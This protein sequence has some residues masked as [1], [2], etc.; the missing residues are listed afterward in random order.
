MTRARTHVLSWPTI[1]S[2][3]ASPSDDADPP[4]IPARDRPVTVED[5]IERA[6]VCQPGDR[7]G[8]LQALDLTTG[9]DKLIAQIRRILSLRP[10]RRQRITDDGEHQ[11][12]RFA[13]PILQP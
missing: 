7:V 3:K 5:L 13:R 12:T 9:I 11:E 2:A 1:R 8:S 10:I 4:L 6:L